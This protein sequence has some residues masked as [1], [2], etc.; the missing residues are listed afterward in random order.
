MSQI[1][2]IQV[3]ARAG[4]GES[5][6]AA[7]EQQLL[8][9]ER[10][11]VQAQVNYTQLV[12]THP[13]PTQPRISARCYSALQEDSTTMCSSCL[14][15]FTNLMISFEKYCYSAAVVMVGVASRGRDDAGASRVGIRN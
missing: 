6:L 15:C 12:R 10:R 1:E 11:V 9:A 13:L 5:L 14:L 7:L 3:R 2:D 4:S 8:R